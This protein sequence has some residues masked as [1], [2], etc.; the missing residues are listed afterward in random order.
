MRINVILLIVAVVLAIPTWFTLRSEAAPVIEWEDFPR[1][2][3]GFNPDNV[4]I[5]TLGRRRPPA[6]GAQPSQ[7][8]VFDELVFFR[9]ETGWQLG[10]H[11]LLGGLPIKD[12]MVESQILD[13]LEA[14]RL[15][16][17]GLDTASADKEYLAQRH[18]I[19]DSALIITCR[20]DTQSK[21]AL[22]ELL[23]GT[24]SEE[25]NKQP[26]AVQGYYVCRR[27]KPKEV[28][29][30][31]PSTPW[32][33]LLDANEWIRKVIYDVLMGDV[34]SFRI[35]N[36][37]GTVAFKKK[38]GSTA[39][40]V[41]DEAVKDQ[42]AQNVGAPR[43]GEVT[44][45]LEQFRKVT[46]E[47][48][49]GPTQNVEAKVGLEKVGLAPGKSK[50]ELHMT[51]KDGQER[52]LRIGSQLPNQPTFYAVSSES[53][54]V[55]TLRDYVARALAVEPQDLFD[56]AA[57]KKQPTPAANPD[58]KQNNGDKPREDGE[59]KPKDDKSKEGGENKSKQAAETRPKV[60]K[61]RAGADGKTKEAPVETPTSR[62]QGDR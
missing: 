56:P 16:Q 12:G 52:W 48:F 6:P 42:A 30:Y 40:W 31:D 18:L 51:L 8:P 2:F 28:V 9:T 58:P 3:P 11:P 32:E 45:L 35:K 4:G 1:L 59:N 50:Y 26:G 24:R 49:E 13:H 20:R 62:K 7:Q 25:L 43:Q 36:E 33:P 10:P 54:F 21:E 34:A 44:R 37:H 15:D 38:K 17:E 23:K 14:I 22:A 41:K 29:L 55:F 19:E 53:D 27:D 60:D 46:A 57:P 47:A 5:V 61:D 39:T